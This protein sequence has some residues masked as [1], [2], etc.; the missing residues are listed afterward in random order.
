MTFLAT[1]YT[2]DLLS[3]KAC[4]E[5]SGPSSGSEIKRGLWALEKELMVTRGKDGGKLVRKLGMDTYTLLY[6]K[7]ITSKVLLYSTWN[8]AQ[9]YVEAWMGGEFGKEWIHVHAWLSPFLS[10]W[11]YHNTVNWLYPK[12]KQEVKKDLWNQSPHPPSLGPGWMLP[13]LCRSVEWWWG[14]EGLGPHGCCSGPSHWALRDH[15]TSYTPASA[16]RD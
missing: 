1:H 7:W 2:V 11:N 4:F 3:T 13:T 9:F 12:T 5:A 14:L 6:L 10:T 8:S 15:R 16:S